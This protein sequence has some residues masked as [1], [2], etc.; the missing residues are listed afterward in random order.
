M[1]LIRVNIL[2]K[3]WQNCFSFEGIKSSWLSNSMLLKARKPKIVER[4]SMVFLLVLDPV[5]QLY[6]FL[7]SSFFIFFKMLRSPIFTS[8]GQAVGF[9]FWIL[10]RVTVLLRSRARET[11]G[12]RMVLIVLPLPMLFEPDLLLFKDL[13]ISW[14]LAWLSLNWNRE[15][16]TCRNKEKQCL[17]RVN[18][19]ISSTISPLSL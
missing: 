14:R 3:T 1:D 12:G 11:T 7:A 6:L 17:N 19:Y 8:N 16:R 10:R 2:G 18:F 15:N 4:R 13:P 9:I 5:F